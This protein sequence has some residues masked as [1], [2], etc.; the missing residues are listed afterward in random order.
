LFEPTIGSPEDLL[1]S[2]SL[3]ENGF[4]QSLPKW[5]SLYAVCNNGLRTTRG[6]QK[7][8]SAI[9]TKDSQGLTQLFSE[10]IAP[11]G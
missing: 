6:Q 11:P 1:F 9:K 10:D 2:L 3:K 8:P 7:T 4:L 5:V